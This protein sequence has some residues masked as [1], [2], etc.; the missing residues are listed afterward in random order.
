MEDRADEA[1]RLTNLIL[2]GGLTRKAIAE[3]IEE[4]GK[5]IA[6]E[7]V[8]SALA[9]ERKQKGFRVQDDQ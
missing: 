6:K 5:K 7:A 9:E 4:Y 1:W 2:R 3:R 8:E